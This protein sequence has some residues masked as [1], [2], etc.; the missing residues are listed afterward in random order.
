MGVPV[1]QS[2]GVTVTSHEP[3]KPCPVS[4]C[5]D[6]QTCVNAATTKIVI[7]EQPIT[8]KSRFFIIVLVLS[9]FG[10]RVSIA[11]DEWHNHKALF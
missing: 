6:T 7:A 1:A 4:P 8:F 9:Y 5:A 2:R 3:T 11:A 10:Q